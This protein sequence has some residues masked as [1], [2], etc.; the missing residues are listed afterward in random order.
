MKETYKEMKF[1]EYKT[2]KHLVMITGGY[3]D[4]PESEIHFRYG[5]IKCG[6]DDGANT[7][8]SWGDFARI[9]TSDDEIMR[10][11]LNGKTLECYPHLW[12]TCSILFAHRIYNKIKYLGLTDDELA[13]RINEIYDI[14]SD[15]NDKFVLEGK[16]LKKTRKF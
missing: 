5:C 16:L 12:C 6:L 4:N 9:P 2:C 1:N 7:L 3:R 13:N 14:Y 8:D 15:I 11:Y 10:E